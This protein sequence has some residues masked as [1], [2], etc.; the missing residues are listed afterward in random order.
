MFHII[1][2]AFGTY[3]TDIRLAFL[4]ILDGFEQAV[5]IYKFN[6]GQSGHPFYFTVQGGMTHPHLF[7]KSHYLKTGIIQVIINNLPTLQQELSVLLW[8]ISFPFSSMS[9]PSLPILHA[10]TVDRSVYGDIS[11][12]SVWS[13][14]HLRHNQKHHWSSSEVLAVN[15]MTGIWAS[16]LSPF[17]NCKKSVPFILGIITS[18]ITISGNVVCTKEVRLYHYLPLIS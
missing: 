10:P 17:I 12:K 13:D 8:N 9:S 7:R 3:S 11:M 16:F 15:I 1:E 5:F 14:K 6:N 18:Q 2:S 4:K